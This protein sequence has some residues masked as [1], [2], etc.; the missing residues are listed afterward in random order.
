MRRMLGIG[1]ISAATAALALFVGVQM[2]PAAERGDLGDNGPGR[3]AVEFV[4]R[5]EQTGL[6]IKIFGYVTHVVGMDDTLLFT[7]NNPLLRN[8]ANARIGFTAETHVNQAFQVL[9]PPATS[10]L[11]DVD[12]SGTLTFYFVETPSGRTF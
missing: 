6:T 5:A 7:T 11:F 9:P 10:S 1:T 2:A 8:E 4:G 3:G 12:S